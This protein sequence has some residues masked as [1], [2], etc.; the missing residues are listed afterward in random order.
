MARQTPLSFEFPDQ[1]IKRSG[2]LAELAR[3][4]GASS[5]PGACSAGC[6]VVDTQSWKGAEIN[7]DTNRD[8]K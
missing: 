3:R 2:E 4:R 7:A 6:L 5:V 1:D 8:V